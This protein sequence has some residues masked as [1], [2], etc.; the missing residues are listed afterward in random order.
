MEFLLNVN[1]AV[2]YIN[3]KD[4]YWAEYRFNDQDKSVEVWG[5]E[6][7][8]GQVVGNPTRP[9]Y[10]YELG[11]SYEQVKFSFQNYLP[12]VGRSLDI[13][14]VWDDRERVLR[15]SSEVLQ[16]S[17]EESDVQI[18]ERRVNLEIA[19]LRLENAK[20]NLEVQKRMG[21]TEE[22]SGGGRILN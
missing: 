18:E 9:I 16:L 19:K 2:Q 3:M 12:R 17:K 13:A 15:Q 21:F 5:L 11:D 20:N 6:I 1:G 14:E 7:Y 4:N 10:R 22:I 8:P